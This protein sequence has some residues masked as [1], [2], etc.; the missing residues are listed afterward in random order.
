ME[1][2]TI[3]LTVIASGAASAHVAPTIGAAHTME[4]H[5]ALDYAEDG[6]AAHGPRQK[7]FVPVLAVVIHDIAHEIAPFSCDALA[8]SDEI[9]LIAP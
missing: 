8:A 1:P 9:D 7:V 2:I 4:N 6:F 3:Q 5:G